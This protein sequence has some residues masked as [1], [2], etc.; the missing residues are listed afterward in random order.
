MTVNTVNNKIYIGV[1]ITETPYEFDGYYGNGITGTSCYWF[2]HPKYPFQK[3]C[4]KY[5]LKAFKRYT[6]VVFD[7]YEEALKLEKIVVNEQFLKRTDV[8]N[9]A[10]GGGSGLIPSVEKPVYQYSLNGDFIK[11]YRSIS[12][13]SRK[14]QTSVSNII[15]AIQLKGISAD[16]YWSFNKTQKLN[17]DYCIKKASKPVYLY[18]SRGEYIESFDSISECA[19]KLEVNTSVI[20][21]AIK[22]QNKCSKYYLSF[23]KVDKFI[24]ETKQRK[25]HTGLYQYSLDGKYIQYMEYTDIK[26]LCGEDYKKLHNAVKDQYSCCGFLWSSKKVEKLKACKQCNKKQIE[27]YDLNGNL[28]K[29]WDSYRE[30]S[31]EFS[32]LRYVLNG[33]RSNTKGFYFKYKIE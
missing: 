21:R 30:C 17:L 19:R 11:E 3:A 1:H 5:G 27:Q 22:K 20:L 14:L 33:A 6:L 25:R 13:A 10:I 18:N 24:K 28:I 4:K 32:N 9:V 23:D 16:S 31:K 29:I 2:K 7:T 26:K 8:Y 12:D 15:S